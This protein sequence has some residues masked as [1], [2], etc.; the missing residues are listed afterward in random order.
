MKEFRRRLSVIIEFVWGIVLLILGLA[1]WAFGVW[2]LIIMVGA[3]Q[4]SVAGVNNPYAII[5]WILV[6]AAGGYFTFGHGKK[7]LRG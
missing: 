4:G 6:G 3:I 5:P 7:V 1:F 2:V